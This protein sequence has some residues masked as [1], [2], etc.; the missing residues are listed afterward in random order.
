MKKENEYQAGLIKR[1]KDRF[2]GCIVLKNDARYIQGFPDLTVLYED[3]WA[4]LETKRS[5]DASRR[6]NQSYYVS[7]LNRMSY[8]SFISPENEE[9][10]LDEMDQAFAP[11]RNTR[12]S[13]CKSA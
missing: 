4:A 12:L 1:I 3:R 2:P 13:R 7:K 10:V 9:D 8:A 11:R 6:P 5:K